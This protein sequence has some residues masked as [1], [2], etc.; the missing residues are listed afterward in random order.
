MYLFS[1]LPSHSKDKAS[2]HQTHALQGWGFV[3]VWGGGAAFSLIKE[4]MK[5]MAPLLS[6]IS[7]HSLSLSLSLSSLFSLSAYIFYFLLFSLLLLKPSHISFR[8]R[9]PHQEPGA[10]DAG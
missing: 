9:P 7:V 10:L 2:A 1:S 4:S 5:T 3:C 8:D 6:I